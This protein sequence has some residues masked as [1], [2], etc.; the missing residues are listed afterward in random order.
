MTFNTIIDAIFIDV[1]DEQSP[2]KLPKSHMIHMLQILLF[3]TLYYFG[4]LFTI[5]LNKCTIATI[6]TIYYKIILAACVFVFIASLNLLCVGF[7]FFKDNIAIAQDI[8]HNRHTSIPLRISIL[9]LLLSTSILVFTASNKLLMVAHD[10]D[11][12]S[13]CDIVLLY[14]YDYL[15]LALIV[16]MYTTTLCIYAC[17]ILTNTTHIGFTVFLSVIINYYTLMTIV[18][19]FLNNALVAVP[20]VVMVIIIVACIIALFVALRD[21][22]YR[23]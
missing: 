14:V 5:Y 20:I 23:R 1:Q 17:H 18:N 12:S 13:P 2:P 22:I 6:D 19:I 10:P 4:M 3:V 11:I 21:D 7:D 8:Q 9:L 15:T 16:S